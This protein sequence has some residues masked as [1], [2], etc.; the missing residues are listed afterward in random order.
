MS[1]LAQRFFSLLIKVA[2][3]FEPLAPRVILY[4]LSRQLQGLEN[5]GR[6]S[7]FHART[8]RLGKFHYEMEINLELTHKQAARALD[9]LLLS[10]L[11]EEGR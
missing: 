9:D 2:F 3:F 10:K 6:I 11:R 1:T 4:Y 8:R 7:N 5:E